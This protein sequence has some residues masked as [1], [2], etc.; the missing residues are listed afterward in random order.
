[1]YTTSLHIVIITEQ[2][3]Q[4]VNVILT[5]QTSTQCKNNTSIYV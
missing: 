1:M 5:D 4:G 2:V 3:C